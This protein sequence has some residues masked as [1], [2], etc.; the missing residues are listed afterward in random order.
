MSEVVRAVERALAILNCFGADNSAVLGVTEIAERLNLPKSTVHRILGT[1]ESRGFVQ[2]DPVTSQYG[3]GLKLMELGSLVGTRAV[4]GQASLPMLRALS[5]ETEETVL[6]VV[7]DEGEVV[8]LDALESPQP[9]K[10]DAR[11]GK[12]LPAYCTG[13]GKA[14]LSFLPQSEVE[15]VIADPLV[16]R[17]PNTITDPVKLRE[18]FAETRRR[19]Y[20]ISNEEYA[21]GI[22]A[23]GAPILSQS[24]EI[25]GVVA[26]A[27]PA[28]RLPDERIR[29][30]G[31]RTVA[32]ARQIS[33]RIR[34]GPGPAP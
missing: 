29:A 6:L 10:I 27:G 20:S 4:L 8:Y 30:I 9:V 12:R 23:V 5:R 16:A 31:E 21:V 7:Y 3:L 32:A 15:R 18:D 28:F 33:E 11:P 22:R 19:G 24:G 34:Y 2:Q 25:W 17:T 13:S 14:F 1:L 26:V